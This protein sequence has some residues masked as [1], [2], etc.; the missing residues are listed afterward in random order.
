MASIK[1]FGKI[2][3]KGTGAAQKTQ[4][5]ANSSAGK[6]RTQ[7]VSYAQTKQPMGSST[8]ANLRK[9]LKGQK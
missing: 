1:G 3:T 7:K 4:N 9:F 2:K 8:V 6:V 5:A